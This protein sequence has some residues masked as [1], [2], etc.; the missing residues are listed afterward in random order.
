[1]TVLSA[2]DLPVAAQ[3]LKDALDL[4][5]DYAAAHA[6]LAWCHQVGSMHGG[7]EGADKTLGLRHAQ[8]A[9]SAEVDDA[10]ALAVGA[11]VIGLLAHDRDA[12]LTAIERAV[13]VNPSAAAAYFHGAFLYGLWG[14]SHSA[15]TYAQR[16]LRLSPFDPLAYHAHMALTQAAILEERYDEAVAHGA[17]L[18]QVSPN[19]GSHVLTY[20]AALTLAGRIE[21]ARHVYARALEIEPSWTIGLN[22]SV[23]ADPRVSEKM[24][25]AFRMLGMPE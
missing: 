6:H 1:L 17:R 15:T 21:E 25:R 24:D 13:L 14:H 22:R 7:L 8:I 23:G 16:A 2:A 3:F 12:A 20:A 19:F 10:T 9:T 18:A 5:P 11:L 4:Q